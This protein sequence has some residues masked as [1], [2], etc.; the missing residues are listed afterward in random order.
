MHIWSESYVS[1]NNLRLPRFL[2][3]L[4]AWRNGHHTES[5][6]DWTKFWRLHCHR[7]QF[8]WRWCMSIRNRGRFIQSTSRLP[9]GIFGRRVQAH[10]QFRTNFQ[11]H[12]YRY[13]FPVF[14]ILSSLGIVHE[15]FAETTLNASMKQLLV[16][17]TKIDTIV[18]V[19]RRIRCMS[20]V[21]H[22]L[23]VTHQHDA[24]KRWTEFF[25]K[26]SRILIV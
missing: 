20:L 24:K 9:N 10:L 12:S 22:R 6:D 5:D 18:T 16:R 26:K 13:W 4:H 25:P 2:W 11:S 7:V 1:L 14:S 8:E 15:I 21:K 17:S 23:H 3:N 19:K